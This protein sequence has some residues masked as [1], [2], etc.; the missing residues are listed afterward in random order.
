LNRDWSPRFL[1]AAG[2]KRLNLS[3]NG[4]KFEPQR[5]SNPFFG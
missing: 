1:C 2:Y 5:V 4:L 3:Q